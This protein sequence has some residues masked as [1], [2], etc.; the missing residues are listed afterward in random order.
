MADQ[1]A[2]ALTGRT[3][4]VAGAVDAAVARQRAARGHGGTIVTGLVLACLLGALGGLRGA[5]AAEERL[6]F[7]GHGA[8]AAVGSPQ[9]G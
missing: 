3:L 8:L 4:E 6:V 7:G 5:A 2:E 1:V 9:L